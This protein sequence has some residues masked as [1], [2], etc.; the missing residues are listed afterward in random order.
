[1]AVV[2]PAAAAEHVELRET[3]SQ[4]GVAGAEVVRVAVV[5]VLHLVQLVVAHHRRVC[6]QS[7]NPVAP[8]LIRGQHVLEMRGMRAV[9][10]VIGGRSARGL[11]D[12]LDRLAKGLAGREPAVGLQGEG[13]DRGQPGVARR[14]SH[15]DR[16]VGVRHRERGDH[17]RRR[18]GER[19]DLRGVVVARGGGAQELD[20]AVAVALRPHAAADHD[21]RVAGAPAQLL[22]QLDR[23]AVQRVE[24]APRTGRA[25][26]PSPGWHARSGSPARSLRRSPWRAAR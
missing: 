14:L 2:G 26:R 8:R 20:R 23:P 1:M 10:H 6:A 3:R 25:A 11:V 17:V 4:S 21:R 9:D 5:Q 19:A 22:H 13:D 16:L 15:A 18:I 12:R 7:A 24:L